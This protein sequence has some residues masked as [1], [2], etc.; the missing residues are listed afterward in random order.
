MT[1][2]KCD[3]K[4]FL[5]GVYDPILLTSH[6]AKL[7][8]QLSKAFCGRQKCVNNLL[9]NRKSGGFN[10]L[11]SNTLENTTGVSAAV[12]GA[13]KH[14]TNRRLKDVLKMGLA[15]MADARPP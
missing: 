2:E 14:N 6:R 3:A 8:S 7:V 9:I 11:L 15:S 10:S 5:K 12:W 13:K 4:L 1:A